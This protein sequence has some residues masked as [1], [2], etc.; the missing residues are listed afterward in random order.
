MLCVRS[1]LIP[2]ALA[3]GGCGMSGQ[4]A[5]SPAFVLTDPTDGG[6]V[7]VSCVGIDVEVCE[8]AEGATFGYLTTDSAGVEPLAKPP[9]GSVFAV[10]VTL[11]DKMFLNSGLQPY[12]V[13]RATE[14]GPLSIA[15][16]LDGSLR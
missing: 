11:D 12:Q 6:P 3:V 15:I 13:V 9:A 5:A 14:G 7:P 2:A 10:R 1:L 4:P 8:G 16:I